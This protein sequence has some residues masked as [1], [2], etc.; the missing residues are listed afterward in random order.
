MATFLTNNAHLNTIHDLD[1]AT[2]IN[3]CDIS[4]MDPALSVHSLFGVLL[5]FRHTINE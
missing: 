1:T 2:G 4:S 5:I 3:L